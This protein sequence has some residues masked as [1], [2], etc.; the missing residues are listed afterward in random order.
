LLAHNPAALFCLD[1][2]KGA[3]APGLDADITVLVEGPHRYDPAA[4]GINAASWSPY[5]GEMLSHRVQG[6]YLR[7][8]LVFD[9]VKVR[10]APGTGKAPGQRGAPLSRAW[11]RP[12]VHRFPRSPVPVSRW[13]PGVAAPRRPC[14]QRS[15]VPC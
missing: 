4:S 12:R 6:T 2:S 1:G 9:G 5:A 7:G 8:E 13:N 14:G 10:A 15:W 3:L 11:L